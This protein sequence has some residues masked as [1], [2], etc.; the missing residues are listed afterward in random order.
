[1]RSLDLAVP[2]LAP[3]LPHRIAAVF[4]HEPLFAGAAAVI[5][6]SMAPV[7]A[8]MAIDD[9]S[10]GGVGIWIKPL[11]FQIALTVYL[12]T[13]AWFAGW[14]PAPATRRRG[15]RLFSVAVVACVAAELA[16]IIGAAAQGQASHFNVATPAR[17]MI[18]SAMGAAAVLLTAASLVQ[19]VAILRAHDAGTQGALRLAIGLGLV[20]T[21]ALTV[22]IAGYLSSRTSHVVGVVP[23]AVRHLVFLGW[24]RNGGD[25]RVAHF[26][27]THAMHVVPALGFVAT[28]LMT[29]RA[30]RHAVFAVAA[31]YAALVAGSFLQALA[32]RPFLPWL[33]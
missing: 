1:M 26:L 10:L 33:G 25:L 24:A 5:A 2:A 8:A 3:P 20:L 12:A 22:P 28:R 15:W 14:V 17:Q 29:P 21:F 18:Y 11:K 31:A 7:L 16:W 30:A 19:G 32:G 9:R 6:V 4:R 13:L 23:D 27:A